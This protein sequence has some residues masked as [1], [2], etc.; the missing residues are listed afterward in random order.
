MYNPFMENPAETI[1]QNDLIKASLEGD[2][3]ALEQLTRRHQA[4][5][6]NIA[7]RMVPDI[8]EAEDITQEILIK[9]ITRLSSFDCEKAAFRTW[10]YRITANHVINMKKRKKE[11]NVINIENSKEFINYINEI[12]DQKLSSRSDYLSLLKEAEAECINGLLQ[13]LDRKQR[14]VFILGNI[15]NVSSALGSDIMEISEANFRQILSR[16]RKKIFNFLNENCGLIDSKNS[17]R[18]SLFLQSKVVNGNS[19]RDNSQDEKRS[20]GEIGEITQKRVRQFQNSYFEECNRLYHG[21]PFYESD[22]LA[23]WL[24]NTIKSREFKDLFLLH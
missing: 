22:E 15:F 4:W 10:L 3:V 9:M 24:K 16:S 18:C 23:L 17:C 2:K 21:Q 19:L 8:S 20:L 7:Y 6:F 11:I 14:L 13:C 5:I 12:P 1:T